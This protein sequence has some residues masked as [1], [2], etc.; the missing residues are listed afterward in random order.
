MSRPPLSLSLS[1]Q[2]AP[3]LGCEQVPGEDGKKFGE[4]ETEDLCMQ[5]TPTLDGSY[6]EVPEPNTLVN[7]SSTPLR[8]AWNVSHLPSSVLHQ[9]GRWLTFQAN[10]S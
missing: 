9:G 3:N 7:N 2:I 1:L 10:L 8:L 6:L 5:A 4:R